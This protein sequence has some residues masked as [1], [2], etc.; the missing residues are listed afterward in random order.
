MKRS[1]QVALLVMSAS[2]L[3]AASYAVMPREDC[4]Q[5]Q[6]GQAQ[7]D[8]CRGWRGGSGG[9]GGSYGFWSSSGGQSGAS[10]TAFAGG[11]A[12]GGFGASGHAAGG[13]SGT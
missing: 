10:S 3:G 12:R 1:A 6:V 11:T 9:H 13:H 5:A 4:G 8:S 2:G 7:P